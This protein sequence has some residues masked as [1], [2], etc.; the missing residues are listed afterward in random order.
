MSNMIPHIFPPFTLVGYYFETFY[1]NPPTETRVLMPPFQ[2][3]D[4][5]GFEINMIALGKM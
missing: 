4:D 5:H 2:Y 1:Y 3:N